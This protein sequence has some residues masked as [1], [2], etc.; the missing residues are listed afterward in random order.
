M[1]DTLPVILIITMLAWLA[2]MSWIFG[3][4]EGEKNMD[5]KWK[6]ELARLGLGEYYLDDQNN[7]QFRIKP[8]TKEGGG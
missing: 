4:G 6:D 2:I 8:T 1:S 5:E 3:Q 7:R